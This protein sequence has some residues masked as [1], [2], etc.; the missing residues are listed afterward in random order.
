MKYLEVCEDEVGL[1]GS[2]T[3]VIK[4]FTPQIKHE[5]KIIGGSSEE[6]AGELYQKFKELNVV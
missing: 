1:S 2:F 3:Q 4:I 5:V 6:Q